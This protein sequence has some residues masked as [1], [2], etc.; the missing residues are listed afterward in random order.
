[1]LLS[2]ALGEIY[3]TDLQGQLAQLELESKLPRDLVERLP[4]CCRDHP[5][6]GRLLER[7][8]SPDAAAALM[9]RE[10]FAEHQRH[11]YFW[12]CRCLCQAAIRF[13]CCA[14]CA[15]TRWELRRCWV[16]YT[17][18]IADC[19]GP[20]RCGII[21]P[22]Q[23]VEE[24]PLNP[25]GIVG[26]AITGTAA[27]LFF[28]GYT[29]E[30]RMVEERYCKDGGGWRSDRV[31]YP[32]GGGSGAVPVQNGVLGWI[33]TWYFTPRSYEVRVCLRA[34][35]GTA[36]ECCCTLFNLFKRRVWIDHVG[37]VQVKAPPGVFDADA[38]LEAGGHVWPVGCSITVQGAAW[39]GEC[40]DR[41]VKC[42]DVRY[43]PGFLPGP[44]ETGFFP[45]DYTGSLLPAP[46][47]YGPPDEEKKR[48]PANQITSWGTNL[49]RHWQHQ[50]QDLSGIFNPPLPPHTVEYD[51]WTLAHG[52]FNSAAGLPACPDPQHPCRSGQYTLLLDVEDTHGNHYYDTQHVWFD[53]KPIHAELH[54]LEGVKACQT[55]SL[56]ELAAGRGCG[57]PWLHPLLGIAY[58]EYILES[59]R[60]WPSDNFDYYDVT[61]SRGCGTA[62]YQVPITE[63]FRQFDADLLTGVVNEWRGTD[64]IGDPGTRCEQSLCPPPHRVRRK[65]AGV[66]T[67]LDLRVFDAVCAQQVPARFRPPPGFALQRGE[68]CGFVIKLF[69]RDKTR[70][71]CGPHPCHYREV[72]CAVCI[73]N[74]LPREGVVDLDAAELATGIQAGTE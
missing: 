9:G 73:C 69:V 36:P 55:V 2:Q 35:R 41:V 72:M 11:P 68:C 14:A 70:G 31:I 42:Y 19:S 20:L 59:D 10:A 32:G 64:R 7:L 33:D 39:V 30:W 29:I 3:R 34:T 23:C 47:C 49:I 24:L 54:G 60:T 46:V 12:L 44:Y 57:T 21:G 38:P 66:L 51:W 13:G 18:T 61:L 52:C 62:S 4:D 16:D 65:M 28:G 37:G 45:T 50:V 40:N 53:N 48:D 43:A 26:I 5:L 17:H 15:R 8:G 25:P 71:D 6:L 74:D 22:V 67:M 58:D 63:D 1:Q 56:R 27:G